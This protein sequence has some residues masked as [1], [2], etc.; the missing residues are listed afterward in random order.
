M[1]ED[2]NRTFFGPRMLCLMNQSNCDSYIVLRFWES[3]IKK[4][5][6]KCVDTICK[7]CGR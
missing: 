2:Q 5:L 7:Y 6:Q 1:A 3:D 4:D